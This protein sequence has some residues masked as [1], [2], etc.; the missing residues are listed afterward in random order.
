MD[1]PDAE[2]HLLDGGHFV[3]DEYVDTVAMLIC[4]FIDRRS[5]R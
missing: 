4:D 5:A 2:L 3:L 1:V